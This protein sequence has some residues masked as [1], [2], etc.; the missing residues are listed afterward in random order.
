VLVN[1]KNMQYY[2]YHIPGK[3]FGVTTNLDARVTQQQG[4]LPGEYDIIYTGDNIDAISRLE[5]TLQ[6]MYNYK[7]DKNSYKQ[8]IENKTKKKMKLNVTEQTTT[9]PTPISELGD[10]LAANYGYTWETD[11]GIFELDEETIEW[12][13]ANAKES[14]F[15]KIRCYIY[16]KA[17]GNFYEEEVEVDLS[18][19]RGNMFTDKTLM[20][21]FD[22]FMGALKER[23]VEKTENI[24]WSNGFHL[25]RQWAEEKGIYSKGDSKTQYVKLMEESGELARAILKQDKPEVKDAIGDMIVVLTNLA[26]LEGFSIEECITSAYNVIKNREGKMVNGTFIKNN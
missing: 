14:M 24:T 20:G 16:N 2:L 3:K 22:S 19:Y 9:F 6:K 15:S 26:H 11:H 13:L 18:G 23:A 7:V 17:L 4:Y 10:L 8:V 21:T 1:K 25:I 12:I 5:L